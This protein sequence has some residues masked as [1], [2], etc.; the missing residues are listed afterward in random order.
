MGYSSKMGNK[1]DLHMHTTASDGKDNPETIVN[2]AKELGLEM[3][4]VTDHDNINSLEATAELCNK[5]RIKFVN[6]VELSVMFNTKYYKE[7]KKPFELHV[8]GYGFDKN[9]QTFHHELKMNE[10][11]RLKRILK[12]VDKVNAVLKENN[13]PLIT[14]DETQEMISKTKGAIGRPHL[15]Q[16]LVDKK[17]VKDFNEA[18]NLYLVELNVPKRIITLKEGSELIKNAGGKVV[19]AH[20]GT[21]GSHSLSDITTDLKIQEKII[22]SM[23]D[24]IDGIEC[25]YWEHSKEETEFYI[26]FAKKNNLIIT[27][28]TDH[29]GGERERIGQLEIDDSVMNQFN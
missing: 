4:S 21:G 6:G 17:I 13:Q 14:E 27:G 1:I 26:N 3:I 28:G 8:L 10:E 16:L 23:L 15:A 25:Y 9:N 12:M 29:H 18:F 7:G 20:P 24:Y 2:K 22:S 5:K 19:L 11:Y